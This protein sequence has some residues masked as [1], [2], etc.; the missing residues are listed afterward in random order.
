MNPDGSRK[1]RKCPTQ[2]GFRGLFRRFFLC[3]HKI[4]RKIKEKMGRI[5][6]FAAPY[7]VCRDAVGTLKQ[8]DLMTGGCENRQPT[9][10]AGRHGRTPLPFILGADR[11]APN[12][13][14]VAPNQEPH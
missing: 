2:G 12:I 8:R 9:Q 5:Y 10:V 14:D 3:F 11:F 4:R 6:I 13:N 1:S 7:R